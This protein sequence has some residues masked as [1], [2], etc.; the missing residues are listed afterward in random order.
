MPALLRT[1]IDH[2]LTGGGLTVTAAALGP[3]IGSDHRPLIAT[4]RVDG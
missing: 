3:S 2:V 4:V 1:P